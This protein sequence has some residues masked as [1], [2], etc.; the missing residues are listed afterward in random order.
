MLRHRFW[1][2]L[3]CSHGNHVI[4]NDL[5]LTYKRD[6]M[7]QVMALCEDRYPD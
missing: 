3:L 4:K 1:K 5:V 2:F 6:S 7:C